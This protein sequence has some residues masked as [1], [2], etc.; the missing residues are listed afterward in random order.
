MADYP[1]WLYPAAWMA[2]L[3]VSGLIFTVV[4]FR[5]GGLRRPLIVSL[6][7]LK[8]AAFILWIVGLDRPLLIVAYVRGPEQAATATITANMAVAIAL[9]A[10]NLTIWAWP[11]I[12]AALRGRREQ[13]PGLQSG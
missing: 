7:W 4:Y 3:A 2:A 10:T 8:A 13:L 6:I 12:S 9:L 11:E 1:E 5:E